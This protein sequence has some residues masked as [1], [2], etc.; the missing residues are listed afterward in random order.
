MQSLDPAVRLGWQVSVLRRVPVSK[1]DSQ[2][3]VAQA[4]AR[5][6]PTKAAAVTDHESTDSEA[7]SRK[8]QNPLH[9]AR[10]MREQAVD[11]LLHLKILQTLLLVEEPSTIVLATGDANRSTF[12]DQG[13]L[14]CVR[15]AIKRGWCVEL[16]AFR[17]GESPHSE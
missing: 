6:T 17:D 10:Q 14:G 15:L 2:R 5:S 9:F 11:E 13:F 1:E 12:N 4:Q 8:L 16:W 3:Q 7:L